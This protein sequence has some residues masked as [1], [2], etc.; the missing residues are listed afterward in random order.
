MK[1]VL[2]SGQGFDASCR[3]LTGW[4]KR[5]LLLDRDVQ[6]FLREPKT[7]IVVHRLKKGDGSSASV[8]QYVIV[9]NEPGHATIF[10]FPAAGTATF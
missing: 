5:V 6:A 3:D 4:V 7:A 8:V 10:S 2:T 1:S 9:S